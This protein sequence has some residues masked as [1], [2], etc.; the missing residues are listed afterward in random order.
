MSAAKLQ[1]LYYYAWDTFYSDCS[2]SLKMAKL[3]LKVMEK[4]KAD[5]TYRPASL[6]RR[7]WSGNTGG[8][9]AE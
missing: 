5:G 9:R 8:E 7:R 3:F 1:E 6:R 2:Q 4:E